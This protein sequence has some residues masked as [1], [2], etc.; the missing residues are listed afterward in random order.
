M[1]AH[2]AVQAQPIIYEVDAKRAAR[3]FTELPAEAR[4]VLRLCDGKRRVWSICFE[5]GLD[6]EVALRVLARLAALGVV[7]PAHEASQRGL[8]EAVRQWARQPPRGRSAAVA[9]PPF[10]KPDVFAAAVAAFVAD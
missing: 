5:S 2:A 3:C 8:P 7:R 6:N 10:S 9:R 1:V 4:H